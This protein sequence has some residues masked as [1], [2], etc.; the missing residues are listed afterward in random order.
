MGLLNSILELQPVS[1]LRRHHALEHAT[2][3]ILARQLPRTSMA[4]YSD[5]Q[6]FWV[7]GD[8][9]TETLQAAVTEARA[10]LLAG[11]HELAIHPN[12]GTNFVTSGFLAGTAAWL[13][14]AGSGNGF[15][16]KIQRWPFVMSLVTL[17]L[18]MVQ[19]LGPMIQQRLTTEPRLGSLQVT[20]IARLTRPGTPLHRVRTKG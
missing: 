9:P 8:L 10:R 18:I 1:R 20:E 17:T 3:Q 7:I 2:L 5:T 12:C 16:N 15:K 13:A 14:M 11:E 19:P 4:G 6:G